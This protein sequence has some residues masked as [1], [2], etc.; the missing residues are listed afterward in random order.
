[1]YGSTAIYGFRRTGAQRGQMCTLSRGPR[2]R[3]AA[4][5]GVRDGSLS[6]RHW[7]ALECLIV[8]NNWTHAI[9]CRLGQHWAA[10]EWTVHRHP[11]PKGVVR[12]HHHAGGAKTRPRRHRLAPRSPRRPIS[13]PAGRHPA[14]GVTQA[15]PAQDLTWRR[16]DLHIHTPASVDFQQTGVGILDILH[17][18][19]ERGLDAIAD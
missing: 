4:G 2:C 19:E 7:A 10:L 3:T 16:I 5:R 14:P 13:G 15:S 8:N 9:I 11:A 12:Y 17:R 1:M 6:T 18:A